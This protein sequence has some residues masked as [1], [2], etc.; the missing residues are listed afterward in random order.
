MNKYNLHSV[1]EK[2]P[3]PCCKGKITRVNARTKKTRF[4]SD[5]TKHYT[6]FSLTWFLGLFPLIVLSLTVQF[7]HTH[8]LNDIMLKT[9]VGPSADIQSPSLS[10]ELIPPWHSVKGVWQDWLLPPLLP[11]IPH[12]FQPL[13]WGVVYIHF[14]MGCEAIPYLLTN[15]SYIIHGRGWESS[16]GK[17]EKR[18][19]KE[20]FLLKIF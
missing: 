7:S 3:K 20:G 13:F 11:H 14:P 15:E 1:G 12:Y 2:F 19:S 17:K 18:G 16:R 5:G 6:L 8:M 4:S 10:V 9:W